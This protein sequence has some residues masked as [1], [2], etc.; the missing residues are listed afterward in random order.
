MGPHQEPDR[1]YEM[2]ENFYLKRDFEDF[3]EFAENLRLWNIQIQKLQ[4][5]KSA[6]TLKQLKLGGIQVV[7]GY[8]QG[9]THQV[10]DTPPGRTIAFH[11]GNN[12]QLTW[13]K[14]KVRELTTGFGPARFG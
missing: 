12:S 7:Y 8:F 10:G 14:K 1:L 11:V 2:V 5:G 3:E 6:N 4:T 13:R 9:K